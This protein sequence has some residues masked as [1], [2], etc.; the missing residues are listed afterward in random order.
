MGKKQFLGGTPWSRH[1][2]FT[3]VFTSGFLAL[4]HAKNPLPGHQGGSSIMGIVIIQ[5]PHL[6]HPSTLTPVLWTLENPSLSCT[7]S[8]IHHYGCL[9]T[10]LRLRGFLKT[11]L[12]LMGQNPNNL[13]T[14]PLSSGSL[15]QYDL[16]AV[17]V[18]WIL[19]SVRPVTDLPAVP[20]SY[21]SHHQYDL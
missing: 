18:L 16:P 13:P 12:C 2:F 14:A 15:H 5:P 1:F 10:D 4:L 20:L 19:S 9:E 3:V 8:Q 7:F 17:A 6:L 21:G 11:Y